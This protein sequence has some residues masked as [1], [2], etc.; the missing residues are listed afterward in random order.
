MDGNLYRTHACDSLFNLVTVATGQGIQTI[1]VPTEGIFTPHVHDRVIGLENVN[2]V[3]ASARDLGEEIEFKRGG[4]IQRR[5][6][7]VLREAHELLSQMADEGLFAALGRGVFG[8]VER[9]LEDGRGLDGVVETGE[10]YFNPA[11]ELMRGASS[12]A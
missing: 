2:Y 6:Q 9:H 11:G 12:L 8:D 5:A 4:I 7:E 3:F 10:E 1:G